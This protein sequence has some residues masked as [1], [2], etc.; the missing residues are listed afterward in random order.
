MDAKLTSAISLLDVLISMKYLDINA[1]EKKPYESKYFGRILAINC[2]E[3]LNN[4][5]KYLAN[6]AIKDYL[7][8]PELKEVIGNVVA[9]RKKCNVFFGK[10]KVKLLEIRNNSICHRDNSSGIE[11][12]RYIDGLSLDYI[13]SVGGETIELSLHLM[14]AYTKLMDLLLK[15]FYESPE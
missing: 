11:Q 1:K 7:H 4:N 10:N 14:D 5:E 13:A 15:R 6:N 9:C 3:L 2:H 8:I 12:I